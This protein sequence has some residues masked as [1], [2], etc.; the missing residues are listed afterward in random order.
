MLGF[1]GQD[2]APMRLM[3]FIKG[4]GREQA[5]PA[6]CGVFWKA[7]SFKSSEATDNRI[8]HQFWNAKFRTRTSHED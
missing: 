8:P 1:V 3:P 5:V 7:Q 2:M 6:E 4:G